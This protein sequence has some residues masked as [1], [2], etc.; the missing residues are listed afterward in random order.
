VLILESDQQLG[1]RIQ[2]SGEEGGWLC[3]R[4]P[5]QEYE[6]LVRVIVSLGVEAKVLAPEE[7]R[8]RVQQEI[9]TIARHYTEK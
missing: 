2:R 4:V 1:P 8:Q 9:H 5:P 7:L 6:W 3:V